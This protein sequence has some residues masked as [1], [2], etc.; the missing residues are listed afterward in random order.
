VNRATARLAL[1]SVTALLVIWAIT[2]A[3]GG[4]FTLRLPFASV[5]SHSPWRPLLAAF[6]LIGLYVATQRDQWHADLR[7]V[8]TI[9][10]PTIIGAFAV[11]AAFIIGVQQ[12]SFF[13]GGPDPSGYVSQ[14]S[15][16]AHGN[17][18]TLIP[19]WAQSAPW[20][21]NLMSAAPVGYTV[22]A[23][24]KYLVPVISPGLPLIMSVFE[25]VGGADAVFYVVPLFGALTIWSAYVFARDLANEWSG[26]IS[27]VLLLFSPAF[28]WMLVE[29]MSDVPVT[30][31]WAVAVVFAC[32]GRRPSDAV[33]AGIATGMAILIR[34]NIAP[35]AIIPAMLIVLSPALRPRTIIYFLM[36]ALPAALLIAM[37]NA[38][39]YGSPLQSGYGSLETLYSVGRIPVNVKR[40]T[41]WIIQTQTGIVFAWA[42]LPFAIRRFD[43]PRR[44]IAI[45]LFPLAVVALYLPYLAF[46]D[47]SY[48]RFL[49]PA[50]PVVAAAVA[51]LFVAFVDAV[52]PRHVAIAAVTAV[53][54]SLISHQSVFAA[55]VGIF[56]KV[57]RQQRFVKAVEFVNTLPRNAIVISDA[58][59]GTLRFY[60]GRDILRWLTMYP[61]ELDSAL[62]YLSERGHPIYFVGDEFEVK[63]FKKRFSTDTAAMRFDERTLPNAGEEFVVANLT[64]R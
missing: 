11:V 35:L 14:A 59:S 40:Y 10:W 55:D 21:N 44:V 51:S 64:P 47:W 34:P 62:A 28:L 3:L 24:K 49:L 17:L 57:A 41:H 31:C 46:D 13:A 22:D 56:E 54:L 38:T 7:A 26:A 53:T 52:T 23:T 29:P 12:S 25:R 58:Y 15:K 50:Y 9:P 39:W 20:G 8:M 33:L 4:G 32:R 6:V 48:L 18:A 36:A 2:I 30:A 42:V 60:T 27:A 37:L 45:L 16:W 63:E 5:S 1:L 43:L 61:H 19:D